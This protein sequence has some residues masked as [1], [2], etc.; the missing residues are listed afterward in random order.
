MKG[1]TISLLISFFYILTLYLQNLAIKEDIV[2]IS[3]FN[4]QGKIT[5][6]KISKMS[7]MC[8]DNIDTKTQVTVWFVLYLYNMCHLIS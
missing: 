1:K 2:K 4:I 7:M 6:V 8:L 3:R 5:M